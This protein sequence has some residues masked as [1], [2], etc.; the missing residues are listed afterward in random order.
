[1]ASHGGLR[2]GAVLLAAGAGVRL[3]RRPKSLLERDGRPLIRHLLAALAAAGVGRTH[4]VLGHHADAL[5]QA[6]PPG[7]RVVHNPDPD[8]DQVASQRLGLAALLAPPAAPDA[9]IVALADQPLLDADDIG[10]L[11]DAFRARRAG[12]EVVH[13]LVHGRRGNPV[14]FSAGAGRQILARGHG[15]GCRQWQAAHPEAVTAWPSDNLH[16]TVDIDTPEDVARLQR[17]GGAVWRWPEAAAPH[18]A[19]RIDR[20]D[21]RDAAVAQQIHAV[22]LPA[23]RQEA[24][25]LQ[26]EDFPPLRRSSADLQA[27]EDVFIGAW[28]GSTLCGALGVAADDE[29]GQWCITLLVVDPARQRRGIARALVQA[30]LDHAPATAFAVATGA[31][32]APALALYR[33]LGFEVYRRGSLGPQALPMV[34]LRRPG[35]AP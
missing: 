26:A 31:F 32:N 9:V 34:K 20:L 23:Y 27:S 2:L 18:A 12:V 16:Y 29:P 4:V 5:L 17:A 15:F 14:I 21:H 10:A 24:A 7:T 13:P 1:M 30:A 25:L 33:S 8:A 6:L 3:G 22:L 19:L 35:T 11:V 28:S